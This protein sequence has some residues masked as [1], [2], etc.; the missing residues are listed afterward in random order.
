MMMN[1][2]SSNSSNGSGTN[3]YRPLTNG[4]LESLALTFGIVG[5]ISFI[6]C[7]IALA[8]ISVVYYWN[9]KV[10]RQITVSQRLV[11]YL[12]ISAVFVSLIIALELM[13]VWYEDTPDI[14]QVCKTIGSML[15]FAIWVKLSLTFWI[16]VHLFLLSVLRQYRW[17]LEVLYVVSSVLVP[18]FLFWIPFITDGYGLA[19]GWCWIR[20]MDSQCRERKVSTIEQFVLWYG[21]VMLLTVVNFL[22]MMVMASVLCKRAC[23]DGN[24]EEKDPFLPKPKHKVVLKETLPLIVYPVTFHILCCVG[25]TNRIQM[26]ITHNPIYGL[27]LAH[28]ISIPSWGVFVS[29][30]VIVHLLVIRKHTRENA[31]ANSDTEFTPSTEK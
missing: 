6:M 22:M 15:E 10:K 26:A 12:M 11:M 31:Y 25:F 19:G 24:R 23:C 7:C 30:F 18:F 1:P 17:W 2:N 27:W 16:N 21:P 5:A 4:Q 28:A 20:V 9:W 3:C 13:V 14:D 29:S 8:I